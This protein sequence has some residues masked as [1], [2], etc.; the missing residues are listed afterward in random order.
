M[1][2][3]D[4]RMYGELTL[5]DITRTVTVGLQATDWNMLCFEKFA[6]NFFAIN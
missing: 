5:V 2:S 1:V 3:F 4:D 6:Y